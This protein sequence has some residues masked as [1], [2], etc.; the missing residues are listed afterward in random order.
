[1]IADP[2]PTHNFQTHYGYKERPEGQHEVMFLFNRNCAIVED[3]E[4]RYFVDN[5]MEQ[6]NSSLIIAL[7]QLLD[8]ILYS[9]DLAVAKI[10]WKIEWVVSWQNQ[11]KEFVEKLVSW[12]IQ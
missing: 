9:V 1:M 12:T 7:D 2:Q 4:R 10:T 6:N 3:Y 5:S 8:P 11:A